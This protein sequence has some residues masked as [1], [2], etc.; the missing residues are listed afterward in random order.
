MLFMLTCNGF[1]IV[2]QKRISKC[3]KFLRFNFKYSK[4]QKDI[5]YK[6]EHML[7]S[8]P[9]LDVNSSTATWAITSSV[10][11]SKL[12][13]FSEPQSPLNPGSFM[14]A[15]ATQDYRECQR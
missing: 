2:P 7:W 1:M 12:P 5:T 13:N 4:H 9:V 8:W 14:I 3:W 11:V 6:E 10:I 15:A